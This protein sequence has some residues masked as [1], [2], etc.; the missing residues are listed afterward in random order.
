MS[1]TRRNLRN[2]RSALSTPPRSSV[3]RARP[4]QS[5]DDVPDV[6]REMLSGTD[7]DEDGRPLKKRKNASSARATAVEVV[8]ESSARKLIPSGRPSSSI[9]E[10]ATPSKADDVANIETP[11][12]RIPQ[13]IE[14]SDAS[15][16]SDFGWEDALAETNDEE[17]GTEEDGD[18]EV[19]DLSIT[20]GEKESQGQGS[21]K[22]LKRRGITSAEKKQ[23]LEIHKLHVLCLLYHIYRRNSWC[24]DHKVQAAL[25]QLPS[26]KTLS[27]LVPNPEYTQFQASKRFIDGMKDLSSFWSKRF[28]ITALGMY[29]PRW[30]DGDADIPDFSAFDDLDPPTDL[31]DFRRAA[32]ILHG[33][34]DVGAQLFCALLRAIGVEARLVCSLQ[35]LPIVSI[36]Q[37][38]PHKQSPAK[39]TIPLDPYNQSNALS[40]TTVRTPSR[41]KR[42]SRL[43]RAIGERSKAIGTGVAP[44][45]TK[46]YHA[47]YPVYWVEAFNAAQQKW[48]PIDPLSTFTVDKPEKLEPPLSYAQNTLTYAIAFEED[49][50]AR[51]VTRRYA[52]AF[53]AKTRKLRVEATEGGAR[54]WKGALKAFKRKRPL[55]RD[56]VEDAQLARKE[57]AEGIPKNVQDFKGHPIYVLERH[58]R[59]NEIIH[60]MHQVGKVNVGSAMNPK[61]EPIYRRKDVHIVRS[62]DKWYRLGRDVKDGEQ[63]LKHAKPRKGVRRSVPPDMEFDEQEDEL[64]VGLYALFQTEVYVPPP[65][66]GGRVPRNVFGNLDVYVP[67]MVPPGGVHIRHKLA[68]KAARIVGVDYADAVTGF[69]F[70]GRHGTA[71]IQGVVVAQEYAEAVQAVIEGITYAQEEEENSQRSAEALRMWRR[72]LLGLRIA[73]RV[74]AIEI[75]GETGPVID[76][77][78]EIEKED[79]HIIEQ[80]LAGGFFMEEGAAIEPPAKPTRSLGSGLPDDRYGGGFIADEYEEAGGFLPEQPASGGGFIRDVVNQGGGFLHEENDSGGGFI[81]ESA[82]VGGGFIP[83]AQAQRASH[84]PEPSNH[85]RAP[86]AQSSVTGL[87]QDVG[88]VQLKDAEEGSAAKSSPGASGTA[89][90][91]PEPAEPP[92]SS[93]SEAGSLPLE[94]PEDED[95]DPEWLVDVT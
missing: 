40:S 94:D 73:Q 15:E 25:R 80:Q 44:K 76:V 17:L 10:I 48:V 2:T 68:S 23:R 74:N 52:K 42:L 4:A 92:G 67:S 84:T 89:Q 65:V 12:N 19:G 43:E 22:K 49:G 54:W 90:T 5:D 47:P 79:K 91:N 88:H 28:T 75:D 81:P 66:V 87:T 16:D 7:P 36:T 62:A 20:I 46:K 59:H 60:P 51:D 6:F 32:T 35:C 13:T 55:D 95:A 77:Q 34:Q 72:F 69:S 61:L 37:S 58:L 11:G 71:I 26:A 45:Q 93:P 14:A 30:T 9:H 57:A 3:R 21:V 78:A 70:K 18:V 38:T 24:N 31:E 53:N 33:S 27:N 50:T 1:N 39:H 41:P 29:K 63:P 64:G 86:E 85:S 83:E 82:N 56:Q 8:A